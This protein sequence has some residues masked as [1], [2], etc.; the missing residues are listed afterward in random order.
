MD[1]INPFFAFIG[2]SIA[3]LTGWLINCKYQLKINSTR[4]LSIDGLRGFLAIGVF[5]NHSSVWYRYLPTGEWLHAASNFYNQLGSACVAIFFM[6]S[7]YLFVNKLLNT[8]DKYDWNSF[9]ISRFFRLAPAYY[10]S[11]FLILCVIFIIDKQ[12]N[13][14]LIKFILSLG[15]WM[16]FTTFNNPFINNNGYTKII[17]AGV[18]WSLRYEWL[19]YFC[20]PFISIPI[21]KKIPPVRII[22]ISIV[23]LVIFFKYRFVDFNHIY[24]FLG[25]AIAPFLIKYTKNNFDTKLISTLVVLCFLAIPFFH[26]SDNIVSKII[27]IIA[28]NFIALGNTIFG[29]LKKSYLIFL[30][31]ICYSTYLLHGILLFI[32]FHLMI[33]TKTAANFTE[34][35]YWLCIF[36]I[37]PFVV[38]ISFLSFIYFENPGMNLSKKIIK[39]LENDHR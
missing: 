8:K 33:G 32:T 1:T 4:N 24:S 22:I 28:F 17:N 23:F 25:G 18:L 36:A 27:L 37:T 19:F 11:F 26:S 21:L 39:K 7:A 3:V 29:V 38:F 34:L 20:L 5:I 10:F 9:F 2:L 13:V 31:E 14:G 12:L 30:G 16:A 35:Q 15:H 6:I